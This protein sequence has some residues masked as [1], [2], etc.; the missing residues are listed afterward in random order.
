MVSAPE[1]RRIIRAR[2][3]PPSL[4]QARLT[5]LDRPAAPERAASVMQG[6]PD[7]SGRPLPKLRRPEAVS[8]TPPTLG[9]I[10]S[11]APVEGA[12]GGA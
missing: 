3:S 10:L 1:V 5:A 7:R 2:N 4:T 8:F 12:P 11:D 6:P 9:V